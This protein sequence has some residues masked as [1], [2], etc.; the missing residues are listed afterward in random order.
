MP[1]T[2]PD[3]RGGTPDH[4]QLL[5]PRLRRPAS[6]QT[7]AP[8]GRNNSSGAREAH[9]RRPRAPVAAAALDVGDRRIDGLHARGAVAHH[10]PA[11]HL[12]AAAQAQRHHAADVHLV[13]RRGGAAEDHLVE[14]VGREGLA[15]SARPPAA[16]ARS[17]AVK[18]ARRVL[19]L[20]EWRACAI[21]DVDRLH[22]RATFLPCGRALPL[23]RVQR[24]PVAPASARAWPGR[25]TE[26]E[27]VGE[28]VDADHLVAELPRR[29]TRA[30]SRSSMTPGVQATRQISPPFRTSE[31]PGLKRPW[32]RAS[33]SLASTGSAAMVAS[34]RGFQRA[35][36]LLDVGRQMHVGGQ[37]VA[38]RRR[39]DA[40]APTSW[41]S[42]S[43]GTT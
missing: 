9:R 24:S 35:D 7:S 32:R 22:G 6:R 20:Q 28:V 1:I 16:V 25:R 29:S 14:L 23:L 3:G 42:L 39:V 26:V 37:A 43:E 15:G 40:A 5:S 41:P 4:G 33:F 30:N 12:V 11:R 8:S 31:V 19:R 38:R 21:D 17:D 27:V 36:R 13:R 2:G 18:R 10:R 34:E